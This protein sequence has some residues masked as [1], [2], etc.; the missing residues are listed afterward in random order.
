MK[1]L[2]DRQQQILSYIEACVKEKGY[3]PSVREIGEAVGLTSSSTVHSHLNK[4]E[5]L[6][7]IRRD[8]QKFRALE[9]IN[10]SASGSNN[11]VPISKNKGTPLIATA[12]SDENSLYRPSVNIP[13]VGTV[14]AGQPILAEQNIEDYLPFPADYI[15]DENTFILKVSGD[16]MIEAGIL[17][18][19]M[20]IVREQKNATNGDIVVALVDDDS[21]TVKA[22]YK[23]ANRIRLQPR[24]SALAPIYSDNVVILGKVIGLYRKFN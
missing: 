7:F 20:V 12:E 13:L 17:D 23:E 14:T 1:K 10:P 6:G 5:T 18:G 22:F 4:L 19:D 11:V 3:P 2:S 24:N 16:S 21:A 9:V 15:R 8:P